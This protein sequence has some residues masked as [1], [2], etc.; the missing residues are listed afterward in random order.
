MNETSTR[1]NASVLREGSE[2]N[3]STG[4]NFVI[5]LSNKKAFASVN[6][7]CVDLPVSGTRVHFSVS[8]S[9]IYL[10]M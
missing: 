3:Q 7:L 4:S 10:F 1:V 8:E 6:S 2:W 5:V 9:N